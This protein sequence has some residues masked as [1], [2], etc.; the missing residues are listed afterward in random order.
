LLSI[1][2]WAAQRLPNRQRGRDRDLHPL[3]VRIALALRT[4]TGWKCIVIT[5]GEKI[6]KTHFAELVA[7]SPIDVA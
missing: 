2:R 3:A 1:R 7:A 5:V 6:G 4:M